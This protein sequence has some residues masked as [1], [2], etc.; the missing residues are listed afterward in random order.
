MSTQLVRKNTHT[1]IKT[2]K[3]QSVYDFYFYFCKASGNTAETLPH[4][5]LSLCRDSIY[6]ARFININNVF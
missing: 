5:Y 6:G 1:Y 3:W 4:K 2:N